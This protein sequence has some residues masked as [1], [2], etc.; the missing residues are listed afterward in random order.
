M[1]KIRREILLKD[2]KLKKIRKEI[3][4]RRRE[5]KKSEKIKE[6]AKSNVNIKELHYLNGFTGF[7]TILYVFIWLAKAIYDLFDEKTKAKSFFSTLFTLFI[8]FLWL[9]NL[10]NSLYRYC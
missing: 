4:N 7:Y 10:D 3:K 2:L 6:N 5:S 1:T 9:K 8:H